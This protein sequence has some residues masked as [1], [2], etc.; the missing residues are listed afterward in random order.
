LY[1]PFGKTF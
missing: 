1:A